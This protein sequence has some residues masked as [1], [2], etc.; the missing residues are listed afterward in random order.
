MLNLN[1][2]QRK[3]R[4]KRLKKQ[5]KTGRRGGGPLPVKGVRREV[6]IPPHLLAPITAVHQVSKPK[7]I[8]DLKLMK[9]PHA[10]VFF[11]G[12]VMLNVS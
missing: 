3:R 1:Q 9:S 8:L 2:A 4:R 6:C 10:D 7:S 12:R 11:L 5:R